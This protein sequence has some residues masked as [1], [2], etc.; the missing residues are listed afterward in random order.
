MKKLLVLTA[1][2]VFLIG[3]A[4]SDDPAYGSPAAVE[5]ENSA[6]VTNLPLIDVSEPGVAPDPGTR[7]NVEPLP[8]ATPAVPL[9][10]EPREA[11]PIPPES[12]TPIQNEQ[13][14]QQTPEPQ[15]GDD[16]NPDSVNPRR[17]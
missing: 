12:S 14:I 17:A 7:P 8:P 4:D 1:C 9:V 2:S 5:V 3:C 13:G 16:A 10:A 15:T 6:I 11:Q